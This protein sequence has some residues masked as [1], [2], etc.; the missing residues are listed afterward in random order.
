MYSSIIDFFLMLLMR[1][2]KLFELKIIIWL[3]DFASFDINLPYFVPGYVCT[4]NNAHS[5]LI[6]IKYIM[7]VLTQKVNNELIHFIFKALYP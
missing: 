6:L 1:F 7:L 2:F 4:P 3:W 5:S